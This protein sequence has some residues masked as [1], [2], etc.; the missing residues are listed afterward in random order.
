MMKISEKRLHEFEGDYAWAQTQI[1]LFFLYTGK[2]SGSCRL[3]ADLHC[4]SLS[5]TLACI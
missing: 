5:I 4:Q 3:C 1:Y 2:L